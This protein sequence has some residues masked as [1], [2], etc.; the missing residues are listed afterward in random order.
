MHT[1][2]ELTSLLREHGIRLTKRLGQ[3]YLVD[4]N[5]CRKL[6]SLCELSPDDTVIEIG[7]GLGALTDLLAARCKRVIAVDVDRRVSEA[8]RQRLARVPN[9]EVRCQDIL[10][11]PWSEYRGSHV[12]GAIPYHITSPILINLCDHASHLARAWLG[13]QQEVARRLSAQPGSKVY[14]RL[15]VLMQ[16]RFVVTTL[17]QISRRAFFPQPDVDSTWLHLEPRRQPPAPVKDEALFFDVVRCAFGQR[18]KTLAN[19][20]MTLSAPRVSREQAVTLLRKTGLSSGVRGEELS[21][22]QFAVLA[23]HLYT[24]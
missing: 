4:P 8:L 5:I 15:S 17:W 11:F 16:Y 9:V 6:V 21:P 1:K 18:R 24:G 2:T 13:M 14:G 23:N 19:C 7:S 3:H 10:E 20:L 12:V 22:A